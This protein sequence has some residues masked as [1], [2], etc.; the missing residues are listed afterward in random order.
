MGTK[1]MIM[2]FC[3]VSGE[4]RYGFSGFYEEIW[5]FSLHHRLKREFDTAE[6]TSEACGWLNIF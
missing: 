2:E 3:F 4:N 1:Y 6:M 5:F